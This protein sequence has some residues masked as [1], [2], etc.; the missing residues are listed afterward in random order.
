MRLETG[1]LVKISE[2]QRLSNSGETSQT[3]LFAP[4]GPI[5]QFADIYHQKWESIEKSNQAGIEKLSPANAQMLS[6][7]REISN[8]SLETELMAKVADGFTSSIRTIQQSQG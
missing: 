6:L 4:N 3:S 7:Q 5:R 8:I 2:P 1:Q